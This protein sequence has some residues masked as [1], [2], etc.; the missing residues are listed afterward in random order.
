MWYTGTLIRLGR[1]NK[2]LNPQ[3]QQLQQLQQVRG[4]RPPSIIIADIVG[5]PIVVLEARVTSVSD[6]P[7]TPDP[8]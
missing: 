1:P 5:R 3:W 2:C 6:T 7:Q 8:N 4:W